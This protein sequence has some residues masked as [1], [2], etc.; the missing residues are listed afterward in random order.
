[1]LNEITE[2]YILIT[3]SV[4]YN[5]IIVALRLSKFIKE[6]TTTT[7]TTTGTITT[8]DRHKY[9]YVEHRTHVYNG[10][11]AV[12]HKLQQP[13]MEILYREKLCSRIRL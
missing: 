4:S 6:T 13:I 7:T 9:S 1:M 12:H 10:N 5:Y 2:K 8:N 11:V 3:V